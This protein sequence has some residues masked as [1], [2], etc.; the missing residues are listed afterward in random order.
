LREAISPP[1]NAQKRGK[2][3]KQMAKDN[4][5]EIAK[6]VRE[7]V[8]R[9]GRG[10]PKGVLLHVGG[11]KAKDVEKALDLNILESARGSEGGLFPAGERP[12]P[13]GSGDA[14]LKSRLAEAVR[15]V[16]EGGELDRDFA[17]NLVAEYEAAN[18]SRRKSE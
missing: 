18:E 9:E 17:R 12:T 2:V 14:S 16:A 6:F 13:K 11:F 10:C 7:Y 4:V 8:G 15:V 1:N 3:R 5:L